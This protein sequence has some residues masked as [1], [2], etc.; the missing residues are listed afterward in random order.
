MNSTLRVEAV[1]DRRAMRRF[2]SAARGIQGQD[3]N[4]V[5]PLRMERRHQWS[6][7]HPF[8]EH[9]EA[10][11]FLALR[12]DDAVGTISAQ[13]DRLAPSVDGRRLGWFGQ[14]EG[15]DDG[16]VFAG[17]L[18][19]ASDWLSERGCGWLRGPFDL[20]INQGC[21]LLVEGRET[22]PML[23]MNHA[24][25]YYAERLEACGLVKAMDLLAYLLPPDFEPPAA[26]QR[27]TRRLDGRLRLRPLDFS[28]YDEELELLRDIFNDAWSDNWGF[29]PLTGAEFRAM[30]KDLRQIIRPAYTCVAEVD[31]EAAG[32]IVALPNINELI[33]DLNG[34]LL[35][36][37]WARLLWR[38]KR[39]LATTARV[40]LMGVRKAHQRGPMGAAVSFS[41]IEQVRQALEADGV[42]QVEL[43]WILESNRGMNSMI[44]AMGGDL[45]KRY[46]L[47]ECELPVAVR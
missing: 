30:G 16:E 10:Q 15:I 39:R 7:R 3:P 17:L 43:S 32:F 1:S 26:M 24:P 21:G 25:A 38:L 36:F 42:G 45:Y 47:Y 11:A 35:P 40:P 13:I 14:L 8:F 37:G 12:G 29:V 4:W 28:R 5:E 44:E 46:R 41:M 34:R 6:A 33:A 22:P 2:L 18:R 27:L 31:G 20:G 23:M 19:A 9:A